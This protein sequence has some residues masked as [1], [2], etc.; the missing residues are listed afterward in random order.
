MNGP[1]YQPDDPEA[2]LSRARSNL[3]L[4]SVQDP[5]VHFEELCYNAQ[6]AAEKALKAVFVKLGRAFPYTHNLARLLDLLV[7]GG[8]GVPPE[9]RRAEDLTRFA[10]EARYPGAGPEVTGELYQQCLKI[11][12]ATL[13]WAEGR[14]GGTR[15]GSSTPV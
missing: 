10:F 15:S 6:Q 7:E 2:W 8:I 1:R 4:A 11:A 14:I 12:E 9:V 13:R 3:R 5:A